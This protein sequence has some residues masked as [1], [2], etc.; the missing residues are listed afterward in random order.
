MRAA[1]VV[2]ALLLSAAAP[3]RADWTPR[4]NHP[5]NS[6]DTTARSVTAA[7]V[8]GVPYVGWS[9]AT[10]SV[11]NGV[12]YVARPQDGDFA[13]VGGAV[14]AAGLEP[15][16]AA[17]GGTPYIAVIDSYQFIK[18]FS[19]Q[20]GAWVQVGPSITA[21]SQT[22]LG[23]LIDLGGRP[24][25]AYTKS[26][27]TIAIDQLEGDTWTQLGGTISAHS[28]HDPG[29]FF[30]PFSSGP[31]LI[32]GG[33][34]PVVGVTESKPAQFGAQ[35]FAYAYR[36]DGANWT[37]LNGDEPLAPAADNSYLDGLTMVGATPYVAFDDLAPDGP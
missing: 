26:T 33:G 5:L 30:A 17:I 2:I 34:Q 28:G 3:A 16:L 19:L 13:R 8:D 22:H 32:A 18:V 24:A 11:G 1:A 31:S 23:G 37:A 12:V 20:S 25:V 21:T 9:E 7:T 14:V 29:V 6:P 15:Q 10:N 4:P 27:S 36:F 35:L